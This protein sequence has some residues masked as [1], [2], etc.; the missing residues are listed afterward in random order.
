MD[1][2][3][4]HL[5]RSFGLTVPTEIWSSRVKV[6]CRVGVWLTNHRAPI[7]V[8]VCFSGIPDCNPSS[9]IIYKP[10]TIMV[11]HLWA[12]CNSPEFHIITPTMT[13]ATQTPTSGSRQPLT[14]V[15]C[16]AR[17]I[18]NRTK[19]SP[20]IIHQSFRLSCIVYNPKTIIVSDY[21]Q[22]VTIVFPNDCSPEF[23]NIIRSSL[24]EHCDTRR[25]FTRV[26]ERSA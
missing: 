23:P 21:L 5:Y 15:P 4:I 13:S 11:V 7:R 20:T 10:S 16:Y 3:I 22:I 1:T 8:P 17:V 9:E 18:S 24:T 19:L 6:V 25:P 12:E 2:L 26:S 14:T